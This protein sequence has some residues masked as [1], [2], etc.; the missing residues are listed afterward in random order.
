MAP[1]RQSV[2]RR[3]PRRPSSSG[4]PAALMI[5]GLLG[6]VALIYFLFMSGANQT[7]SNAMMLA[8]QRAFEDGATAQQ[9]EERL[10]AAENDPSMSAE[11]RAAAKRLRDQVAARD[12]EAQK[13]EDTLIGTKYLDIKL[14]GYATKYL[15]DKP[16]T[17]QVRVFIDRTDYFL[18]RWSDHPER[19]WVKRERDRFK[20]AVDFDAPKTFADIAWEAEMVTA[21][22][23]RDYTTAFAEIDAF[24]E[25]ADD[26]DKSRAKKLRAELVADRAEM[27]EENM[28]TAKRNWEYDK[29]EGKAISRLVWGV[30]GTGDETMSN[31]AA[32]YLLK[33]PSCDA[34]LRGYR[35]KQPLVFER[36][37]QHPMLKE[38]CANLGK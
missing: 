20:G 4:P 22:K 14:K 17:P 5:V 35:S 11:Q 2:V 31:E 32:T 18:K 26:D 21:N 27:H 19:D 16:G 30:I 33:M 3:S 38:R 12:A 25:T 6:G 13:Q 28:V 34:Y 36:L 7:D 1:S 23:P 8:A 10:R 9:V 29:D 24:V 37:A 15:T